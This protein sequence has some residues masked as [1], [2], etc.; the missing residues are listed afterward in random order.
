[1][2]HA[3]IEAANAQALQRLFAARPFWTGVRPARELLPQLAEGTVLHAGPPLSWEATCGPLRGALEGALQYE[4][5]AADAASARALLEAGQI[6]LRP[7]HS[8]GAVGPMTGVVTPRMPLL[9]VENREYGNRA[10]APLNEG[11]G[12]VL[13]FGANDASVLARL[14]W[15]QD[16]AAPAL[17]AA[18]QRAGGLDLRVLMAQALLMGDELH[19]R[20]VAASALVL[21]ALLPHLVRVTPAPEP[22]AAVVDFL[23]GNE[24][25]FLNLA[26]AAA[27]ATLD[28]AAGIPGCTLVTA[29]ARNGTEF[30]IRLSALGERWFTA[31]APMPQGLY[32]PG[33]SAADANPDLGDSAIVETLGLGAFAMAASPAVAR[34]VGLGSFA[35][36]RRVTEAMLD[37]TVARSPHFLLPTLDG[38]GVPTGI[39][40]RKVVET[41]I[42][43]W[44]N[45]GIAHRQAGIGQIGAGVVQAPL[46]CF[47]QALEAF[48]A[49]WEEEG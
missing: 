39:D 40:V 14:R 9:V 11:L 16:V 23:S 37:I 2:S 38:Q 3:A 8:V 48:A 31:P 35:E 42:T 44:I 45:T 22:L 4:G 41:G 7:C 29:M 15:L 30:G 32:F 18:L 12:R 36:A 25:F 27:K 1:M 10:Y 26:M 6:T 5:W 19:Q 28:P 17:D 21:R 20:N 49:I 24:Q 43:P 46:A 34:F 47:V 13:R 33:Y